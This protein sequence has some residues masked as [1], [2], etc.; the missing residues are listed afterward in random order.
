MNALYG[1]TQTTLT[2]GY[3]DLDMPFDFR[4]FQILY[5]T[6]STYFVG[7]ALGKAA[8][9]TDELNKLFKRFAWERQ[10]ATKA[11]LYMMRSHDEDRSIDQF[12]FAIGSLL[13]LGIISS[14]D[15]E[16]VMDRFRALANGDGLIVAEDMITET[17]E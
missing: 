6:T 11:M 12:E 3:G 7:N 15:L 1:A 4:W 17:C 9:L 10:E 5:L 16:P 14:E 2:I 13:L 8:S